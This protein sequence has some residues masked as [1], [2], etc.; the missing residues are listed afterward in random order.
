MGQEIAVRPFQITIV[1]LITLLRGPGSRIGC[2]CNWVNH[3]YLINFNGKATLL[4]RA[5]CRRVDLGGQGR[6]CP[7]PG[8][9]CVWVG[10]G[11]GVVGEG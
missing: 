11:C 5:G 2:L 6:A 8:L 1:G 3:C 7:K 10:Q 4:V 9:R